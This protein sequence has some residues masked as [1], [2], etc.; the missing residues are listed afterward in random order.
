MKSEAVKHDFAQKLN[1]QM[2]PTTT[3]VVIV[4][5]VQKAVNFIINETTST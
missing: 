2:G 4:S 5:A 3:Y 1:P